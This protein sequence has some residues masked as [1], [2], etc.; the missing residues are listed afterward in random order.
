MIPPTATL[1][2][3][4]GK[5]FLINFLILMFL[6]TG[7]FFV[8]EIVE[9]LRRAGQLG[10]PLNIV[11]S[12]SGLRMA[13]IFQIVMPFGILF[14]AIYTC[15]K[16]NK[17]SE[18]VV[19]RSAGIS[20]WQFLSP[21]LASALL[22]GIISTT[23]INPVAAI[24]VKKYEKMN[25]IYFN[26]DANPV[27]VSR[28]GIWLRQPS[29]EGYA[30]IHAES[31]DQTQ[32]EMTKVT[33]LFFD[34]VDNF[35]RRIDSPVAYLKEGY[36]EILQATINDRSGSDKQYSYKIPTQLTAGKIV[37][38]LS[39]PDTISFWDI[40]S[41]VNVMEQTGFPATRLKMHFQS[42]LAQ[43]FLFAAMIL[44]AATFSLRP[45][46]FGG[47]GTM[48]VLGV[49]TGFFIFFMESMLSAFGVSQKIPAALAAWTPAITGLLF[50]G[51]A[52]LHMEDG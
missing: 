18:L 17:T 32:W 46:R 51:T 13:E 30:L 6:L 12:M 47:V 14:G 52:L 8:F 26:Q 34:P 23:V 37:E 33:V 24:F 3:C 29:N 38:S 44:L 48:I 28:T 21:I 25:R 11:V 15:W 16:L 22:L 35:L 41:Y 49:A 39:N 42:L 1:S 50:G 9:T 36:W 31:L 45:T 27:T 5:S 2:L 43:P 10:V 20:V 19:M 7:V 4:L 40:P